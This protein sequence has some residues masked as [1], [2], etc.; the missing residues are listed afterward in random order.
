[1]FTVP[2][3]IAL[4]NYTSCGILWRIF[5]QTEIFAGFSLH[6]I[7]L[8]IR[9]SAAAMAGDIIFFSLAGPVGDYTGANAVI[10]QGFFSVVQ[11]QDI[12]MYVYVKLKPKD[13]LHFFIWLNRRV[14]TK[15]KLDIRPPGSPSSGLK[16]NLLFQKKFRR[17]FSAYH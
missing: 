12:G 7:I 16:R 10:F 11:W 15:T 1:M 4:L 9:I 2:P 6:I 5:S 8:A 17:V 3:V 14:R 13:F